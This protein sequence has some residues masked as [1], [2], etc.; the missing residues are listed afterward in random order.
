[1]Q[2]VPHP[3]DTKEPIRPVIKISQFVVIK[4]QGFLISS[5]IVATL[6]FRFVAAIN[7][8]LWRVSEELISILRRRMAREWEQR[9]SHGQ[10]KSGDQGLRGGVCARRL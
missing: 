8:L 10:T 4:A 7:D 3:R 1:M 2:E 5:I 9:I 6:T